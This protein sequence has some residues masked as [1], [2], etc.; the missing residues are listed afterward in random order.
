MWVGGADRWPARNEFVD[1]GTKTHALRIQIAFA[2]NDQF[3]HRRRV[4]T[5]VLIVS[6]T[7]GLIVEPISRPISARGGLIS[8]RAICWK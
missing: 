8:P 7:L 6:T 3:T 2:M 5:E 1:E 4:A